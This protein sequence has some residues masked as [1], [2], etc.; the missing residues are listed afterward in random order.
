VPKLFNER[1]IDFTYQLIN[2]FQ[3]E[4]DKSHNNLQSKELEKF[5][6]TLNDITQINPQLQSQI[7]QLLVEIENCN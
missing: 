6:S 2:R 1:S 4:F 3:S 7:E 5:S